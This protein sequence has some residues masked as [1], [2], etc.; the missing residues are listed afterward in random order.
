MA[1]LIPD[2]GP[3]TNTPIGFFQQAWVQAELGVP[4]N[5]T[6]DSAVIEGLYYNV[7]G[8]PAR[9]AGKEAMEN[10][11]N[12]GVKI[13]LVYGDRDYRCPWNSIEKLSLLFDWTGAE[14][15]HNAGY[16]FI[17]TN[18]TYNGGVVRQ[19]GNLSFSRV[20]QSGHGCECGH[21]L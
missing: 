3:P 1:H 4:L 10:L 18:D 7:V 8:D 6:Q 19:Y 5:F 15:F 13:A 12:G 21:W 17:R 9:I 16:E 2:P 20:F 11:L 14:S